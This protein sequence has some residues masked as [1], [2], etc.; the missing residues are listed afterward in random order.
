MIW[1]LCSPVHFLSVRDLGMGS[2]LRT[3][4]CLLGFRRRREEWA[5]SLYRGRSIVHHRR[6]SACLF[7]DRNFF[8]SRPAIDHSRVV[9]ARPGLV[10][11]LSVLLIPLAFS[12]CPDANGGIGL[13]VV[14]S[15]ECSSLRLLWANQT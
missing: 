5:P 8:Q 12:P 3:V 15:P 2:Y 14:G 7:Q 13:L 1:S 9:S 6:Y 11:L 4:H 10:T